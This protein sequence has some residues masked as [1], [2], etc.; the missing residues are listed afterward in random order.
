MLTFPLRW[1]LDHQLSIV[2]LSLIIRS[3]ILSAWFN[4]NQPIS[5][6]PLLTTFY[7]VF[8]L[9]GANILPQCTAASRIL[10]ASPYLP[11]LRIS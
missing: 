5:L 3:F 9:C 1:N 8:C 10:A 2:C 6:A 11:Q 4:F 7:L